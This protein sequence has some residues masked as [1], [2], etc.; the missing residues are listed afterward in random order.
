MLFVVRY[1]TLCY[2]LKLPGKY[3]FT[4]VSLIICTL[5]GYYLWKSN[6]QVDYV[7]MGRFILTTLLFLVGLILGTLAL[8]F[9]YSN[10]RN[11]KKAGF[12]YCFIGVF[13]LMACV[14]G[15]MFFYYDNAAIEQ[16]IICLYLFL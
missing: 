10:N 12:I 1:F 3:L 9:K 11:N 4:L 8:I 2:M 5:I 13:N 6:E 14:I 16:F 15:T 7:S